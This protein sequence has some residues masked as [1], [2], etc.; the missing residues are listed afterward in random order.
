MISVNETK[1]K[2]VCLIKPDVFEDHRGQYVEIYNEQLYRNHGTEAKFVED[3]ISVSSR[4]VLRGI[5]GDMQTW[6][7]ISCLHGRFYLVVVNCDRESRNFGQW[8]SFVLSAHNRYQVLV[9]ARY[10]NAHLVMSERAIFH[11]KQSAYYNPAGQFTYLW[12][13]PAFDIWWPIQ[14]PILSRRDETGDFV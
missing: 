11:Y 12:N 1:L 7:L 9:P 10:G 8:Q 4:H 6:K 3:D 2:G 13:D 5:H 14:N